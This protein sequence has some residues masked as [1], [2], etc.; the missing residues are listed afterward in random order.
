MSGRE[1]ALPWTCAID[2]LSAQL[3][4][5]KDLY[6]GSLDGGRN[7]LQTVLVSQ[8]KLAL[9]QHADRDH[10]SNVTVVCACVCSKAL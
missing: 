6:F 7:K 2:V 4:I 3:G 1:L 10:M 9:E 5:K 8:L